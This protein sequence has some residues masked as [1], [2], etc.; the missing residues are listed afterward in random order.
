MDFFSILTLL[1]GL[2][3]FLYGMNVMGDGLEK[4]SGGKMEKILET[5]TSN[6]LK[7]VG[8]G[9][10]VTAVIQSSSA[11][12]VMVVGFVNSGIMKLS[13]A[14]GVIMG[15]N[16]GTTITSWILS[17]S[18]IQSDNFFIQLFKPTT[19]SPVLALIGVAF[20]MFAKSEKKKDIGTIFIGF[21]VLM[22]GMES[23]S[24][25]VKPLADVPEFTGIL[26]KFS[27]PILGLLAGMI[28][29]AVIQSSSASVGILQALCVTGAVGYSAA[30]PI[31][32][33]QNIG[34]CITALLSAIGAKKN[35]KRAAMVHLYFNIIGTVVFMVLFYAINAVV[36][37]PFMNQ[38]ANA[39][40][41]AVVHTT[42]NVFATLLLLPFSKV[43]EKL[44]ILT[45]RDK[46]EDKKET[47][48]TGMELLD[49]R[50]LDKPALAVEQSRRVA[51][52]MANKVKDA[53]NTAIGL[54]EHY[55]SEKAEQV[56]AEEEQVDRYEDGLGTYLVKLSQKD[57]N[58][59]DSHDLSI[60]LHCIGDFERISDHAV[61]IMRSAKELYEKNLKF[62]D[63]ALVELKVITKAVEDV[64]EAAVKGFET[65][66][67]S[68]ARSVEPIEEVID[69]L[70]IELKN[71]HVR[72]LRNGNCTIEQ[73]FVLSDI[74]ASLERVADHCSNVAVCICQVQEDAFDTH[75]YLEKMKKNSV[76][77]QSITRVARARYALQ[78]C[79]SVKN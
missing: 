63:E 9:A 12:T 62:S 64:V 27:N 77:F 58:V 7:A 46:E 3:L 24:G 50:F 28:L 69:E 49:S 54:I 52:E 19:F 45:I 2:A 37:F 21:A 8:L 34:T 22:F 72:R 35:A 75:S 55:D 48:A 32:M 18:G 76:E 36:Q 79:I 56:L 26:T 74:T 66:D 11:T 30:I 25:A 1:G 67:E 44:A 39:A 65:K 42:F 14:V 59:K 10:A 71:R 47:E 60:M 43:L 41:I 68:I 53:I 4:V 78:S 31:I 38:A 57:L 16:I 23:M 61:S 15:A 20:L 70:K 40:G 17:L 51:V 5:L 73:G 33:G 29:T 6:P 13:Q